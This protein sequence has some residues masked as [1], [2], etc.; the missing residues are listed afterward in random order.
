MADIF[1]EVEEGLRQDRYSTALRKYGPIGAVLVL[2]VVLGV[3]GREGWTALQERSRDRA[4]EAF[5]TA[6]TLFET[7]DVEGAMAGFAELAESGRGTYAALAKM[8]EAAAAVSAGSLEEGARFYDEAA[9]LTDDPLLIDL[10]RLKAAYL[11][12]DSVELATLEARLTPLMERG[13][14][15]ELIARELLGAA[16]LQAGDYAKA[17]EAYTYLTVSLE[18]PGG[19]RG[20]AEEALAMIDAAQ[21]SAAPDEEG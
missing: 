20:R 19:V 15:Y 12:A 6:Q 17:R 5:V 7:G 16:A 1:D 18:A 10:A 4:S 8:Q 14:P 21:S 2:A 13:R 9:G 3:A 11:V